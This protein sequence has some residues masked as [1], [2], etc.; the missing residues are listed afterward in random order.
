[1]AAPVIRF[2]CAH[3]GRTNES[4]YAKVQ[5]FIRVAAIRKAPVEVSDKP[6][7]DCK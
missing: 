2:S 3:V 1:M 4:P 5:T 6:C 7:P